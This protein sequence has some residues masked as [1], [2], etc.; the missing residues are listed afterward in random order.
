MFETERKRVTLH[1]LNSDG[2]INTRINLYPKTFID[3]IVDRSGLPVEVQQKLIAGDG[4]TIDENNVISSSGGSIVIPEY[5]IHE[6]I[7]ES[8][9]R[10]IFDAHPEFFKL[11]VIDD[12]GSHDEGEQHFFCISG[13]TSYGKIKDKDYTIYTYFA[14]VPFAEIEGRSEYRLDTEDVECIVMYLG[15]VDGSS[16]ILFDIRDFSLGFDEKNI[17]RVVW[18]MWENQFKPYVDEHSAG[19]VRGQQMT[20]TIVV[21][22]IT[23]INGRRLDK[24]GYR[25]DTRQGYKVIVLD[26]AGS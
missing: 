17:Q 20:A 26:R 9:L 1:P 21:D 10:Q 15:K 18:D 5:T 11:H 23:N 4:I 7:E 22:P 8:I 12:S 14:I 25:L 16:D 19:N 3:G 2:T 6:D 13:N 24:Y